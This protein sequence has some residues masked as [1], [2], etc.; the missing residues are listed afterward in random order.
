MILYVN[1]LSNTMHQPLVAY[2]EVKKFEFRKKRFSI[3][4]KFIRN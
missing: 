3:Y 2:V 4:Y 1:F